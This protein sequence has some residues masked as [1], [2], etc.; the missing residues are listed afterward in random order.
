MWLSIDFVAKRYGVLPSE[1]LAKGNSIDLF[2][3]ELSVG[4]ENW[5]QEK[6][7]ASLEGRPFIS[8]KYTTEELQ[9][10]VNSVKQEKKVDS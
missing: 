5:L 10:F 2:C 9:E 7:Q 3:S 8:T 1:F 6:Q 4:Y